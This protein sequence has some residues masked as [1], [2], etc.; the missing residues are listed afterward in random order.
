[1]KR[2]SSLKKRSRTGYFVVRRKKIKK[3]GKVVIKPVRYYY[4]KENRRFNQ[5]QVSRN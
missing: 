2:V 4:D 1:M 5:K 3:N